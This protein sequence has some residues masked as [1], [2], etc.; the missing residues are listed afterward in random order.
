MTTLSIAT[1]KP[2]AYDSP[3]H[4]MPWGTKN[5]NTTNH[6]FNMKLYNIIPAR[7]VRLLDI[8]CSGGG[9]VK[10]ILDDGGFGI[11]VEGSDYSKKHKRAEWATIPDHLF[12]ADATVDFQLTADHPDGR[13]EPLLFNVIT[14]WEFFEHIAEQSLPSV[15]NNIKRHLAPQGIVVASI[16]NWD[17][18][19]NGVRL[20]QS[21]HKKPWWIKMFA[22]H[23]LVRVELLEKYFNFD[24]VRGQPLG[25]LGPSFTIALHREGEAVPN[26]ENISAMIR[27]SRVHEATRHFR[28]VLRPSFFLNLAWVAKRTLE[29]RL[30]GG[31][32]FQWPT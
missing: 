19:K 18:V 23:G 29:S 15:V 32:P 17:D 30:P 24:M 25:M 13:K 26:A 14:A 7:K 1:T 22:S 3:D 28:E 16:A 20:H 9:L 21:V 11:G 31:R 6:R 27:T 4:V 8:G 2:V 10:S 5:D 12:T